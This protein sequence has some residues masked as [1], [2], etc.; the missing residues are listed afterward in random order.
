VDHDLFELP[1]FAVTCD[2]LARIIEL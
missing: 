1:L 2:H